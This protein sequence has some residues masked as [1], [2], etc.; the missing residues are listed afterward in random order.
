[1]KIQFN[2]EIGKSI[3]GIWSFFE[4]TLEIERFSH[5][6]SSNVHP[7]RTYVQALPQFTDR[8]SE[9]TKNGSNIHTPLH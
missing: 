2:Q 5:N 6:S 9:A 1:M 4:A 8:T 3:R 7:G